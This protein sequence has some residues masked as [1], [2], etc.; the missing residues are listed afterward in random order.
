[1]EKKK[2]NI[3]IV[4]LFACGILITIVTNVTVNAERRKFRERQ[5][6]ESQSVSGSSMSTARDQGTPVVQEQ[7]VQDGASQNST[8]TYADYLKKFQEADAA[9]AKESSTERGSLPS[10][11]SSAAVRLKY[12]E[13]QLNSLYNEILSGLSDEEAAILSKDEQTWQEKKDDDAA[14][15]ASRAAGTSNENLEYLNSEIES[16]RE[17]AYRLLEKY[18]KVL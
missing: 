7:S 18:K 9:A 4:L 11:K 8:G 6:A 3:L 1:M 15:A 10:G 16:T 17:R 2:L 5:L 12:W 14:A 13:T